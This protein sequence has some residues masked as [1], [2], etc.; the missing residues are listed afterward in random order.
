MLENASYNQ[1]RKIMAIGSATLGAAEPYLIQQQWTAYTAEQHATWAELVGRRMPQ[2]EAHA[3][4]EYL[5]GF[6]SDWS[7]NRP[8]PKSGRGKSTA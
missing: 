2:I 1:G 6:S 8:D 5:E 3:C 7:Q 4:Q